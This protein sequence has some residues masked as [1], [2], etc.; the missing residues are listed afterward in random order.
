[1][2]AGRQAAFF[3]VLPGQADLSRAHGQRGHAR[4]ARVTFDALR[5]EAGRSQRALARFLD[6][7]KVGYESYR[8]ANAVK[9]TGGKALVEKLAA[10]PDVAALRQERHYALDTAAQAGAPPTGRDGLGPDARA[11]PLLGN[12]W[13]RLAA[14]RVRREAVAGR[15]RFA[16]ARA[17]RAGRGQGGPRSATIGR[18]PV[19][20]SVTRLR[21]WS[22]EVARGAVAA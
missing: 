20:W 7:A 11:A 12:Y 3:V 9:V 4:K 8:T 2:A 16:A 6:D 19:T 10:R 1:M 17:V 14:R 21:A 13:L 5:T 15:P 18:W 22:G